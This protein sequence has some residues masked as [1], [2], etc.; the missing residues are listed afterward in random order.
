MKAKDYSKE[1]YDNFF[2]SEGRILKVA[3]RNNKILNGIFVSIFH[4]DP[5]SGEPFI[6][7]WH[8]VEEK[9][10]P[11][12][13]QG[14]DVAIDSGREIGMMIDQKDIEHVSFKN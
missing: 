13:R 11:S 12:Y 9:D 5:D 7:K 1:I 4:G 10:I 8:F 14:L 3:L 6:V 2:N